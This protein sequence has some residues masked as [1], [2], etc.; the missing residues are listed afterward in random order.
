MTLGPSGSFAFPARP[1]PTRPQSGAPPRWSGGAAS[2]RSIWPK[3]RRAQFLSA[4]RSSPHSRG[5]RLCL[6][7]HRIRRLAARPHHGCWHPLILA[8]RRCH[9]RKAPRQHPRV[10]GRASHLLP[11]VTAICR[12]PSAATKRVLP[13]RSINFISE[14]TSPAPQFSVGGAVA[15]AHE[16]SSSRCG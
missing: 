3:I 8:S 7:S 12:V 1:L 11:A 6:S 13:W 14:V 10:T 9:R 15:G 16:C 4:A 5:A 2:Q